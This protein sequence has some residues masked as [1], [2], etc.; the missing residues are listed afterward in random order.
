MKIHENRVEMD[1]NGGLKPE[2]LS[3]CLFPAV[4]LDVTDSLM[5][6]ALDQE[7]WTIS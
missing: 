7:A 3:L 2:E 6:A 4:C 1:E 5:L